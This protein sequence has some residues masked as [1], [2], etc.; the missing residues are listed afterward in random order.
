MAPARGG[1]RLALM[2]TMTTAP[3]RT[4]STALAPWPIALNLV[5][6]VAVLLAAEL[7]PRLAPHHDLPTGIANARRLLDIEGTLHLPAERGVAAWLRARPALADAAN[8]A[9]VALHVP[10]MAATLIWT[11]LRRPRGFAWTRAAFLVAMALTVAGYTLLP[12]APP[13]FL[14]GAADP[15]RELYGSA[16]G[17][18]G[19]GAV[20][21]LAAF[22]SGHVV[23]A[24]I[25]AIPVVV[26]ARPLALRA[27][28]ALYPPAVALLVVATEHHYWIDAAAGAAVVVVAALV[29]T[30]IAGPLRAFREPSTRLPP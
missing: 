17:P 23:F 6:L 18:G 5:A 16:A 9:Y 1:R 3:P 25:A 7:I 29:A 26:L 13:R 22:P 4:R 14:P 11:Y 12:T 20:N 8:V 27:L 15:A 24:L 28:A 19:D 30:R 10:A 2:A 21:A